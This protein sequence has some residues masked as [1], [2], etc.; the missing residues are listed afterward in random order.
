[1]WQWKVAEQKNKH[2]DDKCVFDRRA[3]DRCFHPGNFRLRRLNNGG[4]LTATG[5][6]RGG[7]EKR[8]P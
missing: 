6:N 4:N 1:M 8:R 5:L 7:D 2:D 3:P